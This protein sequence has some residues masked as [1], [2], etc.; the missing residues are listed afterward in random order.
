MKALVIGINYRNTKK[1]LKGCINDAHVVYKH[2]LENYPITKK[3][4]RLLT[5]E[6]DQKPTVSNIK[7]SM[8]WLA[9]NST[10]DSRLFFH[11]SGHGNQIKDD[12]SEEEDG[13]D[14]RIV[15][16]DGYM[17]DDDIQTYLFYGLNP[18]SRLFCVFDCCSSGTMLDLSMP[19]VTVIENVGCWK[20]KLKKKKVAKRGFDVICIG[21]CL[22]AEKSYET[23][24]R[25]EK[26]NKKRGAL[27]YY[28]Y[29]C[30][31]EKED[32]T[33]SDLLSELNHILSE[34]KS[35]QTPSLTYNKPFNEDKVVRLL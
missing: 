27:S 1:E 6:T 29:K 13:Y 10:P 16:L 9:K 32:I 8:R 4:I 3:E 21:G 30:L 7:V 33:Y 23:E 24:I 31:E 26:V 25:E 2:L 34:R 20:C 5:D 15:G 28:F 12:S 22:D 14:E 19:H 18:G 35:K 11:Y 17:K